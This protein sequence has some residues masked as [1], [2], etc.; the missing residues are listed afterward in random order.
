MIRQSNGKL[1]DEK[2]VSW[3]KVREAKRGSEELAKSS[4]LGVVGSWRLGMSMFEVFRPNGF[5]KVHRMHS[6]EADGQTVYNFL[7]EVGRQGFESFQLVQDFDLS[8]IL[9]PD[10]P[11]TVPGPVGRVLVSQMDEVRQ[12]LVWALGVEKPSSTGDLYRVDVVARG[13]VLLNVSWQQ[14]EETVSGKEV[15]S[16]I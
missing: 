14:L 15:F 6:F 3:E 1:E 7:V 8:R 11:V 2:K 16:H 5:G 12:D 4:R 13:E 9:H 10:R